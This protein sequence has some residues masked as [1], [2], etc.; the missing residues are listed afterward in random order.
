MNKA[1]TSVVGI[2]AII[3]TTIGTI[4]LSSL[5]VITAPI[6][7]APPRALAF[8]YCYTTRDPSSGGEAEERCFQQSALGDPSRTCD[9]NR[10]SD[11]NALSPCHQQGPPNR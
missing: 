3:V 8:E 7:A 1:A 9:I 6:Y 5:V 10:D 11:P 4:S 2:I